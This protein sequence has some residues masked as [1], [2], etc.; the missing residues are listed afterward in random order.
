MNLDRIAGIRKQFC[1]KAME[2]WGRLTNNPQ[3]EL[4]GRREQIAGRIQERYGRAKEEAAR[5]LRDF[6][7]QN[8]NWNPSNR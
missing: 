6:L 3:R 7:H 4:A 2:Q 5:Q 8:R 1:G